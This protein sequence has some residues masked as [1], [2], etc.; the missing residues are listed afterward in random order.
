M[1]SLTRIA[2]ILSDIALTDWEKLNAI[3]EVLK[4]EGY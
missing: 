2:D 4:D 3:E 1:D